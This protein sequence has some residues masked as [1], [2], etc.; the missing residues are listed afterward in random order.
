MPMDYLLLTG[1]VIQ[2]SALK[3][4]RRS[5]VQLSAPEAMQERSRLHGKFTTD[6][7]T[8]QPLMILSVLMA[9]CHLVLDKDYR[10]LFTISK[11][12]KKAI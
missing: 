8:L 2:K 10:L 7:S 3:E 5:L 9:L 6:Y 11:F 12:D 1:T 4:T